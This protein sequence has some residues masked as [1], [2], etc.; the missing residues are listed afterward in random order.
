MSLVETGEPISRNSGEG[1]VQ[2]VV[3]LMESGATE[4]EAYK[5]ACEAFHASRAREQAR[6]KSAQDE[7]R[8]YGA[9]QGKS[10]WDVGFDLEKDAMATW[11]VVK[12]DANAQLSRKAALAAVTKNREMTQTAI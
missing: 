8:A 9:L 3:E 1:V 11:N 2:H 10:A 7:A 4:N 6:A 5:E 12:T